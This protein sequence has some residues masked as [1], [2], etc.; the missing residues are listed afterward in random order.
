[1]LL[2]QTGVPGGQQ[3]AYRYMDCT[4]RES[5]GAKILLT[6]APSKQ[7]AP[8]L[9]LNA[10]TYFLPCNE[11]GPFKLTLRTSTIVC[12]VVTVDCTATLD[13]PLFWSY[14]TFNTNILCIQVP[15]K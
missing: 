5:L 15:D 11:P 3:G 6:S 13:P 2:E 10:E 7:T 1:M 8:F 4:A 14:D 9:T 12:K